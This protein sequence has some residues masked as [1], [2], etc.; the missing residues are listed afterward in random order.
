MKK[1]AIFVAATNQNEGKTTLCLGLF[2][3]L[4]KRFNRVGFIKPV[5][6]EHVKVDGD[7]FVDKDVLL[8]KKYFDLDGCYEKM[9]PIIFTKGYTKALL[10]QKKSSE[11]L[12]LKIKEAF[13]TLEEEN[14]CLLVEGTGH[15][16]VG[17]IANV[18]NAHV[19][20][21]LGVDVILI[22]SAGIGSA[23]DLICLNKAL[24]DSYG[25]KIRGVILNKAKPDK[26]D[27]I[28]EYMSKAL[29]KLD[30]PILGCIPYDRIL[31]NPSMKDFESLFNTKLLSGEE[32]RLRHFE[33]TRLVATSVDTYERL[34]V[35]KQLII[36]PSTREDIIIATLKAYWN[37]KIE[38]PNHDL[39]TGFI[40]TGS[41][42]P[43]SHIIK[44][45]QKANIPLLYSSQSS[46]AAM[47]MITNFTAKIRLEDKDKIHEA[48]SIMERH[49]DFD[50]LCEIMNRSHLQQ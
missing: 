19:A 30:I 38:N 16:G 6:Q 24:C 50:L 41:T 44:Q 8:F 22:T 33:K 45:I 27:M 26:R 43:S 21:L 28:I 11:N 15:M 35:P 10:D 48:I 29:K 36:T 39:E 12:D 4:K 1:P 47:K 23:F 20:A 31:S 40:F 32:H 37:V 25:V 9:S 18:N 5:G 46:F 17:S 34:I 3:G 49:I 2:F 14:D 13:H 7:L 42:P